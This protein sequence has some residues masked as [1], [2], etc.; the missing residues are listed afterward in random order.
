LGIAPIGIQQP[1]KMPDEEIAKQE[2][3]EKAAYEER[4]SDGTDLA[5]VFRPVADAIHAAR[6]DDLPAY[7]VDSLKGRGSAW[8]AARIK[9]AREE[10]ELPDLP[11]VNSVWREGEPAGTTLPRCRL[12]V[13]ETATGPRLAG[14]SIY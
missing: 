14:V 8:V 5:A 1:E 13:A 10:D 11:T 12:I 3:V 4:F 2:T 6:Y 9:S 7:F